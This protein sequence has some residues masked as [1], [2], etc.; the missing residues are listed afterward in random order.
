MLTTPKVTL[1][2]MLG[3]GILAAAFMLHSTSF[4][5]NGPG[6]SAVDAL[7]S[8]GVDRY[9]RH[10]YEGARDVFARAYELDPT[11]VGTLFNLALPSFSR[12]VRSKPYGTCV[13]T[14]PLRSLG[15]SGSSPC[16]R[17]GCRRPRRGSVA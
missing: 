12:R 7:L 15:L 13:P 11:Q 16:A 1:A 6:S 3:G 17:S 10:D 9:T 14:S 4:A 8:T 2:R 5:D